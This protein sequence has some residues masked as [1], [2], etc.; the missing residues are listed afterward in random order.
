MINMLDM[1]MDYNY[2]KVVI[3]KDTGKII[4]Q[5]DMGKKSIM[6]ATASKVNGMMMK[7]MEPSK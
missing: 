1:V 4:N 6:M 3:M 7:F 5:M 2:V